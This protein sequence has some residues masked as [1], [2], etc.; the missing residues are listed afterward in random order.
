[1]LEKLGNIFDRNASGENG[2]SIFGRMAW[3]AIRR[4]KTATQLWEVG[5]NA[6]M[7]LV[8]G[9]LLGSSIMAVHT[10]AFTDTTL[11]AQAQER[12]QAG[13]AAPGSM[14]GGIAGFLLLPY[15]MIL[16]GPMM[17]ALRE[18]RRQ[19]SFKPPAPK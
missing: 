10:A 11:S 3:G 19:T 18:T 2:A 9:A 1:M 5:M 4:E 14:E 15:F 17:E 13:E 8:L 7:G 16:H 6:G 12:M